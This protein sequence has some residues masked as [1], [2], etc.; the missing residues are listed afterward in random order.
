MDHFPI[1][2]LDNGNEDLLGELTQLTQQQQN[3][4]RL[5]RQ[6]HKEE[7]DAQQWLRKVSEAFE[8]YQTACE[9]C[10]TKLQDLVRLI[11]QDPSFRRRIQQDPIDSQ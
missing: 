9:A 10:R 7:K 2:N 11:Q 3:Y 4:D 6:L 5:I 1:D 8:Q